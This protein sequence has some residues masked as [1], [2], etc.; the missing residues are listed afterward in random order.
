MNKSLAFLIIEVCVIVIA[1]C[2]I[3]L[4]MLWQKGGK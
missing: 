3:K 4:F 2:I 1:A